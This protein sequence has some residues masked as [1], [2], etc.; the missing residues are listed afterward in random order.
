[1]AEFKPI[2]KDLLIIIVF[3][4]VPAGFVSR[5]LAALRAGFV[6]VCHIDNVIH[7]FHL[8]SV[9]RLI[10]LLNPFCRHAYCPMLRRNGKVLKTK[11]PAQKLS[12][13]AIGPVRPYMA[14]KL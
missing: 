13:F 14:D 9:R 6:I 7:I 1:M 5:V 2:C 12:G 11:K 10:L 4:A 8:L 3:I